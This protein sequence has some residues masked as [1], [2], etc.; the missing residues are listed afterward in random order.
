[1]GTKEELKYTVVMNEIQTGVLI[2]QMMNNL[3]NW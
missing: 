2:N 1:M 3:G